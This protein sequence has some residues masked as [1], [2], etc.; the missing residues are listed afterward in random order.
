MSKR[1]ID[2]PNGVSVYIDDATVVYSDHTES[3]LTRSEVAF[4]SAHFAARGGLVSHAALKDGFQIGDPKK[5]AHQLRLL[6]EDT[7]SAP[8]ILVSLHGLGYRLVGCRFC[9]DE[10]FEGRLAAA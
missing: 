3:Y 5:V 2:L 4:L 6:F 10:G 7:P 1:R 9:F 8:R